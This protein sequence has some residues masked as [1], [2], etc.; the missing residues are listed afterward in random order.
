[1]FL[2]VITILAIALGPVLAVQSQ[3]WIER[4]RASSE[5]KLQIFKT[6]M[7]TRARA[8]SYE[9][10]VALNMI[11]LEFRGKD[12]SEIRES[13][14]LYRNHLNSPPM[15]EGSSSS[16]KDSLGEVWN[17]KCIRLQVELLEKMGG[18]LGYK[19]DKVELEKDIY[20]P[21][22]HDK[23]ERE[24]EEI[25]QGAIDVLSGKKPLKVQSAFP[26]SSSNKGCNNQPD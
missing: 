3:K 7:T 15:K 8:T 13:W 16:E 17:E 23:L 9:H 21:V 26:F 1:M 19:F 24:Q 25:R 2:E 10:V 18:S 11:D 5:R 4:R 6:L 22:A 12:Y 14:K 20:I